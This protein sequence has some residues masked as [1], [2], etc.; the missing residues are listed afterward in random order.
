MKYYYK[1]KTGNNETLVS[2]TDKTYIETLNQASVYDGW[3]RSYTPIPSKTLTKKQMAEAPEIN[4]PLYRI[5]YAVETPNMT[6]ACVNRQDQLQFANELL[7]RAVFGKTEIYLTATL[8]VE[9]NRSTTTYTIE[10]KH[11]IQAEV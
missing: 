9:R 6:Y 1:R 7:L 5:H 11:F 8:A 4:V 3:G 2:C 10:R